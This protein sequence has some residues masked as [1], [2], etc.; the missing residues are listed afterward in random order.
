V[1]NYQRGVLLI[2]AGAT[3]E[4]FEGKIPLEIHHGGPVLA[5]QYPGS[6]GTCNQKYLVYK[7]FQCLDHPPYSQ[8]MALSDYNL[9]S[10]LKNN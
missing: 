6:P 2:S 9:I 3:E 4:N 7:G 8:D 10:G 1:P 5:R